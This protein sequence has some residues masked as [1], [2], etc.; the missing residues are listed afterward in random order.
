VSPFTQIQLNPAAEKLLAGAGDGLTWERIRANIVNHRAAL[1]FVANGSYVVLR[2]E[3]PELHIQACVGRN[4]NAIMEACKRIA[5]ANDCT[6]I[7][8]ET[9]RK[10]MPR[11]LREFN[12]VEI[13]RTFTIQVQDAN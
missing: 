7:R 13:R 3:R 5:L 8:F 4:G 6:H 9:S 11:L 10:G 12:P 2:L 1:F